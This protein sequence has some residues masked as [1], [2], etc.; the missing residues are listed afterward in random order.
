MKFGGTSVGDA[1]CIQRA[2]AIVEQRRDSSA[3]A[4]AVVVVSAAS[5]VTRRLLELGADAAA[6]RHDAVRAALDDL[7]T[8]HHRMGRE[9]GLDDAARD[10]VRQ[11]LD[12]RFAELDNVLAEVESAADYS[13]R[14][15]DA[16]ISFGERLSS[17]LLAAA[18]RRTGLP[19]QQVAAQRIIVT[20]AGFRAARPD[21]PAIERRARATVAPAVT[22]GDVVVTEGFIGSTVSGE[23][24]T[25]GFEASDLS[26]SL[27]GAA[28]DAR[29][30]QIWT[31]VP[32]MLSTGH[33]AI[34]EPLLVPRLTFDEAAELAL[35]GA[36]VLHP[37][38]VS[39][40]RDKGIPVRILH[41]RNPAGAG[42]LITGITGIS[43]DAHPAGDAPRV[44]SIAVT[45]DAEDE[46]FAGVR[47]TLRWEHAEGWQGRA[48]VCPV[49]EGI[50]S[51]EAIIERARRAL[52]GIPASL[53]LGRRPHA[54]PIAVSRE[55]VAGAV[56]RLHEALI[57]IYSQ[58]K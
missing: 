52:D 58:L 20:D 9:L 17:V 27:L 40:V 56:A 35:F 19:V 51:S 7:R 25:M 18:L 57:G 41:C 4:G 13:P 29:E 46:S 23:V 1:A 34:A 11:R 33:E 26:A 16:V 48:I 50:G 45:E 21:R 36:K 32:G 43:G 38:T 47:A 2:A 15:Q 22:A 5:G 6:G 37:D 55:Q 30:V 12:E 14:R 39:P 24:T 44:K 54:I 53:P 3:E 42:T 8:R 31:D 28:L 10:D 49:G